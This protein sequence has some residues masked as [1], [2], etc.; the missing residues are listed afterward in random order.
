MNV[1]MFEKEKCFLLK[2]NTS[3]STEQKCKNWELH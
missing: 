3:N 1:E 2:S